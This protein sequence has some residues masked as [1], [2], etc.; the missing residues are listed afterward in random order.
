MWKARLKARAAWAEE[1][2]GE[3]GGRRGVGECAL[4]RVR[5]DPHEPCV[6]DLHLLQ[7]RLY[8]YE[9]CPPS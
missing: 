8:L 7:Q 2:G 9:K 5:E 3:D 6:V 4:I 1:A